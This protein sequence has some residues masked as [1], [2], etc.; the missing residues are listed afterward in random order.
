MPLTRR[1][2]LSWI[3]LLEI[4]V[5]TSLKNTTGHSFEYSLFFFLQSEEFSNICY[6]YLPTNAMRYV[7]PGWVMLGIALSEVLQEWL[8]IAA[9][10]EQ[11][12]NSPEDLTK[13]R[14]LRLTKEEVINENQ[15]Y[16]GWAVNSCKEKRKKKLKD[17]TVSLTDDPEYQL[18]S[19]L[20]CYEKDV[21]PEYK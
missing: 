18:I 21:C 4:A 16:T 17:S 6:S 7:S 10:G 11:Q 13:R 8:V 5:D 2:E 12:K 14:A 9:R 3:K 19:S 15:R 1:A 20:V